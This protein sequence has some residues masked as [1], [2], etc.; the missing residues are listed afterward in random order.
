MPGKDYSEVLSQP[1]DVLEP[2][3]LSVSHHLCT[4][5]VNAPFIHSYYGDKNLTYT[6][7]Q[8]LLSRAFFP[9]SAK[10]HDNHRGSGYRDFPFPSMSSHLEQPGESVSLEMLKSMPKLEIL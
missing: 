1:Q 2:A 9:S 10:F 8:D 7:P 3:A 6:I 5:K 4:R